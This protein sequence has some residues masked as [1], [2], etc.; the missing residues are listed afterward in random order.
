MSQEFV[1]FANAPDYEAHQ[2]QIRRY[3]Q[4]R[5]D[6]SRMRFKLGSSQQPARSNIDCG[7]EAKDDQQRS[8]RLN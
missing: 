6:D 4:Q 7:G 8:N 3:R 2:H 5:K 1:E